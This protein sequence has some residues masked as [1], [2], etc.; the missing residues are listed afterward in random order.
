MKHLGVIPR[1]CVIV[2]LTREMTIILIIS[3]KLIN[4][5]P[6]T[7]SN[8]QFMKILFDLLPSNLQQHLQM[9]NAIVT[10]LQTARTTS[11]RRVIVSSHVESCSCVHYLKT[12]VRQ[13]LSLCSIYLVCPSGEK[14]HH[15]ACVRKWEE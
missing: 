2:F 10:K 8:L 13:Y 1:V 7:L 11:P 4:V 15:S 12:K 14:V 3:S 6:D 5:I 9:I